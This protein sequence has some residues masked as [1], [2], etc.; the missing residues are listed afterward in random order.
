MR[1]R[2]LQH[3]FEKASCGK[4]DGGSTVSSELNHFG[5]ESQT[6]FCLH[7]VRSEVGG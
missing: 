7:A 6:V 1:F 3:V 4:E 5:I 2:N